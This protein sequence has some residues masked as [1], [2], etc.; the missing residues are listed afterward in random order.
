M[1]NKTITILAIVVLLG[2]VLVISILKSSLTEQRILKN[3]ED[4]KAEYFRT[5]DS[6][7]LGQLDDTV[8]F[9]IDSITNLETYYARQIDSLNRQFALRDSLARISVAE[10]DSVGIGSDSGNST[11]D[12]L[13]ISLT[14]D[15]DSM[16]ASL[17]DDLTA[18]EKEVS[19]K[20]LIIL[21]SEKY[22]LSPD[23]IKYMI[24]PDNRTRQQKSRN[25]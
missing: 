12:S 15:Y 20:E 7:L 8:V 13:T 10:G 18:Y 21:L 9:Y 19:I 4:I 2:A 23:S 5:R 25:G 3:T 17:P 11:L 24:D 1:R 22:Q 6:L 14:A 16:S